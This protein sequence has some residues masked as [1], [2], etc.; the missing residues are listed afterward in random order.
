LFV[1]ISQH[2]IENIRVAENERPRL[3]LQAQTE[4]EQSIKQYEIIINNGTTTARIIKTRL[5]WLK[6]YF[7]FHYNYLFYLLRAEADAQIIKK[8][9]ST[10]LNIYKQIKAA[11]G[12]DNEALL[13][14]LAVKVNFAMKSPARTSYQSITD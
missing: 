6:K 10:D 7:L 14:Y 13:S 11:Q 8:Q 3:I 1:F 4:Y 2:V 12:L 9:Y 5:V